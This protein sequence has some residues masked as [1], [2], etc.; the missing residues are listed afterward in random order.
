[1][2]VAE[3]W[4]YPVKSLKGELLEE[5]E[6]GP[7]G[8]P[9]DRL[10][11]LR[12]ASGRVITSRTKP[13]LLA[14][15]GTLGSGGEPLVEGRPWDDPESLAAVRDAAGA[16]VELVRHD[17]PERFDVLPLTVLTDGSIGAL[18]V[19]RRRLRPNILVSGVE[20]LA[21]R[22]WPGRLLRIG[23][24]VIH[25]ARLRPRCVMT[26]Y[27]LDTQEQDLSVLRRIVDGFGGAM[28][29]DCAVVTGGRIRIGDPVELLAEAAA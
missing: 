1:M 23:E 9:G 4:R 3:L 11:L 21:E 10:V 5:T 24:V 6:L 12:G 22:E 8:I 15:S 28:A 17:G 25:V 16:D 29:L 18:G 19:D 26:T 7:L 13:R 2:R 27:D 14:L 20:G